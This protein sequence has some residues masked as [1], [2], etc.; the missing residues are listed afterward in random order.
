MATSRV[1][2]VGPGE[3]V[4]EAVITVPAYFSDAQ[5]QATKG[6][7]RV[8]GLEVLPIINEPAAA[9]LANGLAASWSSSQPPPSSGS[10]PRQARR[11]GQPGGAGHGPDGHPR[12]RRSG[13]VDL[14]LLAVAR[15][16]LSSLSVHAIFTA[17]S[18]RC[19]TTARP[20]GGDLSRAGPPSNQGFADLVL[21]IG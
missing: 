7:G 1:E 18:A 9:A 3:E 17:G 14:A 4:T 6:A 20:W 2:G 10:W 13:R 11:P 19:C 5:R 16:A 21:T 12:H 15:I 8:A